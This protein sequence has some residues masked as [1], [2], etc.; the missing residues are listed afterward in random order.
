MR[1]RIDRYGPWALVTGASSGIG[2]GFARELAERGYHLVLVSRRT[3]RLSTLADSLRESFGTEARVIGADLSMSGSATQIFATL[4]DLDIGLLISNAGDARMGGFLQNRLEH[5]TADLHLNAVSHM[6]L[7]HAF[8]SRL[9]RQ[10]RAGGV[11]LVSSTAALQPVALGANYA[12]AKAFV[13]SFGESLH[14]ELAEVDIDVT[15]VLPG[16]TD[17]DGLHHRDDI[18]MDNLPMPAMSVEALVKDGLRAL[19]SRRAS[20]IAGVTNRVSARL[21]PRRVMGWMMGKLLRPHTAEHLLPTAPIAEGAPET[22]R[23]IGQS[24]A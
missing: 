17:T 5:M 22:T 2:A 23:E 4:G 15:V 24:A 8:G 20:R 11:V 9:R 3:D 10:A 19:E 18:A 21:M 14:S 7:V 1:D 16:P 6:E 12:A 13:H